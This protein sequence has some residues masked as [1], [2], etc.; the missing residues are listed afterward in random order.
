ME[1]GLGVRF[2]AGNPKTVLPSKSEE[3]RVLPPIL[4]FAYKMTP[5]NRTSIL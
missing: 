1:R 5:Q 3:K 2:S 4:N